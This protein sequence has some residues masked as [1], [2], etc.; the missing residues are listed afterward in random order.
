M[1]KKICVIA[2]FPPP[3]HGL[4]KAVDTLYN[5][6]LK[7]DYEFE[8]V[9]ITDNKK[10]LS[11]LNKIRKS[12]ADLFY[13]T[14]AQSKG[15][16]IRDLIILKTIRRKNK[17]CLIHL[18]GGYYRTLIEKECGKIQRKLNYKAI[19]GLDGVIVLGNSLKYIFEGMIDEKKIFV[20]PNCVDDEF[21]ISDEEFEKKL[22]DI[23]SKNK[24]NVLYLSNFIESKGY[25]D[26][27]YIA[28]LAK[29]KN[30]DYLKF[31]FAGKFYNKKD[32]EWF[33]NFIKENNLEDVVEYKGIVLGKE[34]SDLLKESDI[35]MLLT[36]YPKEGQPIS[37]I[38]AM[39]NGMTVIT[40]KHAGIPDLIVER[41]NGFFIKYDNYIESINII[42]KLYF[43]RDNYKEI[44]ENNYN[45]IN[46]YL[47]QEN[48]I[49]NIHDI[50]VKLDYN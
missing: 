36:R 29:E 38:E 35:F 14:I 8:K 49:N 23:K 12:D 44:I 46:Q 10:F 42:N 3:I 5:S 15:G 30:I 6:W 41:E 26:V 22:E 20:V 21:L 28:K 16:N 40:T 25:K 18:H 45:K 34:K 37:I 1:K 13:F 19:K 11:N 43:N 33:I 31:N 47:Q 9:N 7:D 32:K 24:L 27:L 17:K 39:G 2:Q 4:S 48:Y 50:F